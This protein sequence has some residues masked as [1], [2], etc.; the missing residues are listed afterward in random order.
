MT[1]SPEEQVS[2]FKNFFEDHYMKEIQESAKRQY[3][4]IN[5]FDIAKNDHDLA[6]ELLKNPAE[7]IRA[8]EI[9]VQELDLPEGASKNIQILFYN[10]PKESNVPLNEINSDYLDKFLS[11]EGYIMKPS[12]IYVKCKSAKFKCPACGA[13]IPVMMLGRDW[14]E[15]KTCVCGR[16]GKFRLLSQELVNFQRVEIQEAMDAVPE[17]PRKLIKKSVYLPEQLTRKDLNAQLQPGQKV[18]VFGY[19]E[20]EELKSRNMKGRSN[21]FKI[22]LTANNVVPIDN[23]WNAITFDK[24]TTA[25]V[26]KMASDPKLLDEFSQ[27]LAPSFEGYEFARKSLILQHV[28]GKRIF[29]ENGN[30]EERGIIHVLLSGAPG[31]GKTYIM[32]K[33]II[34]SP[35]WQ[36][37]QGAGLTKAGLVACV[38]K[39]EFGSYVLD[40]GPFVMA[41]GGIIGIDEFDKTQKEDFGIMNNGM[42]DEQTKITKANIDQT[43]RT[44]TSV[45]ATSNPFHKRFIEGESILKQLAPIPSDL[46][47]RFDIIWPMREEINAEKLKKKYMGRHLKTKNHEQKWSNEEMRNYIAYARRL[48]PV[49]TPE[50]ADYFGEQFKKLTG[51]TKKDDED[52]EKSNRLTGNIFRWVYAHTK[53]TG[54]GKENKKGEVPV[55]K[56]SVNYAFKQMKHSFH[57]LG[58]LSED[59]FVKYE[60][61]EDMPKIE[62]VNN[63]YSIERVLKKLRP[64]YGNKIPLD[65]LLS[66]AQKEKVGLTGEEFEKEIEKMRKKGDIFEPVRGHVGII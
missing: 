12:D 48:T 62:E 32:K 43:L 3:L 58:I 33:S 50:V 42:N 56:P 64:D 44:R 10:L 60:D 17:K 1:L 63:Y 54:V 34:I 41:D 14:I 35:L 66:E 19:L 13:I 9:S 7:V 27:S 38:S 21:E 30:L 16:K 25:K 24:A 49:L 31:S 8:A 5:F 26:K 11:F 61:V 18:K 22:N 37:T 23:S 6:E 47:D 20:L 36:W 45:L 40:I 51:K 29:D 65:V 53:F 28:G 55:T 59:G 15:P 2:K 4:E 52:R 57:L 39:D 46:V